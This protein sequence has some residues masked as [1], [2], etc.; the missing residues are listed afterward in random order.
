[1]TV[2]LLVLSAQVGENSWVLHVR[3]N[4]QTSMT[5]F[6]L[7]LSS[8][9]GGNSWG[10]HVPATQQTSMTGSRLYYSTESTSLYFIQCLHGLKYNHERN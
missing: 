2:F 7:V 1:M 6:L 8:Q 4:Q 9:V 5:V 3:A 10:L